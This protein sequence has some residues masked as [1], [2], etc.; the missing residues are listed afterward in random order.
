[1]VIFRFEGVFIKLAE[2]FVECTPTT[3]KLKY[4]TT[5]LTQF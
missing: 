2:N 5:I 1:M 3:V 4:Y